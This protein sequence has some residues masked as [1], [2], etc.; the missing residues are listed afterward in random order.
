MT[1]KIFIVYFGS[2]HSAF[3]LLSTNVPQEPTVKSLQV[4]LLGNFRL[5]SLFC[6]FRNTQRSH[7]D[8]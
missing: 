8:I 7:L 3:G 4:I 6:K 2:Q 5:S 1:E